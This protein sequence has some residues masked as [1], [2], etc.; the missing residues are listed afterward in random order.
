[1][2]KVAA[3]LRVVRNSL[4]HVQAVE[5][6]II[7]HGSPEAPRPKY[8]YF[9]LNGWGYNDT[10]IL[11]DSAKNC[12]Y[13]TGSRYSFAKLPLTQLEEFVKRDVGLDVRSKAKLPQDMMAVDPPYVN[14]P[15]I[16][17]L[18][19][20]FSRL[21]FDDRERM[22]HSHGHTLDEMYRAKFGKFDRFADCVVYPGEHDHVEK[23][24]KLA[25]KHGVV[26]IPYGGGTNVTKALL[27]LK[28]EKR[29][30]VSIDMT[31]MNKVKWVDKVNMLACAESGIIGVDLEKELQKSG[32]CTGHE[33]DSVEFSTLGGWI[34]TRA[35]GM[36]KNYY[37]NIEDIVMNLR[38]VTPIGTYEKLS[39]WPRIS[40]GPDL[41][42]MIMG[43][44][45]IFGIVTEATIRV[46]KLAEVHEYD[47]LVFPS[48]EDGEK[49][50]W[51]LARN[52]VYPASVRLVDNIQFRFA[53][54]FSV[55]PQSL[56]SDFLQRIARFYLTRIKGYDPYKLA[57]A[58]L[59]FEG[60]TEE[61][62]YQKKLLYE[63]A[64]RH[65]GMS[66]GE[67]NGRKGYRLTF[68]IAY[69]RDFAMEHDFIAESLETSAPWSKVLPLCEN[70]K[71]QVKE[72][73]AKLG[74]TIDPFVTFRITLLYETGA[75]VYI[76]IAICS[77][78]LKDPVAAYEKIEEEA[79]WC[80]IRNGGSLSHHHGV[81]KLRKKFLPHVMAP[82]GLEIIRGM[83]QNVD[84]RNVFAA[85]NIVDLEEPKAKSG[86][87]KPS[88]TPKL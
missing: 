14:E 48:F 8:E 33:P 49:F 84:P 43:S 72:S 4:G 51:E 86:E 38:V 58:T 16:S 57:V 63:I 3:K 47:S 77:R 50:M 31:R 5:P 12:G 79:R 28:E 37:G 76:Y 66:A 65:S 27:L 36:K 67:E 1:M 26:L 32:V 78:G 46:R 41:F 23:L 59:L 13:V 35:S 30:I 24:V 15:F 10:K 7:D 82:C 87:D 54:A 81:G 21:S 88:P 52:R 69:I 75:T 71:K 83:K 29:M 22:T 44:E 9:K 55:A 74:V 85:G 80:I 62:Q 6:T 17:D 19:D 18:G 64:E 70:T 45:G 11:F 68:L 20:S 25:V 39:V 34:A 61:T 2:D 53:V 42:H 60:S 56:K 73:A 40:N